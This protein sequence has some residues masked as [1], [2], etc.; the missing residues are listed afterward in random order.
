[1]TPREVYE[2]Y[3]G[4]VGNAMHF[5]CHNSLSCNRLRRLTKLRSTRKSGGMTSGQFSSGW[6]GF[7]KVSRPASCHAMRRIFFPR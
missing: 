5:Q 1:M 6:V 4:T 7:S 2:M 3:P